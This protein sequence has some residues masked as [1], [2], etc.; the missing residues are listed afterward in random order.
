MHVSRAAYQHVQNQGGVGVGDCMGSIWVWVGDW[1]CRGT[2][3]AG[4]CRCGPALARLRGRGR[5]AAAGAAVAGLA[6]LDLLAH[7]SRGTVCPTIVRSLTEV[8]KLRLSQH[9]TVGRS[10]QREIPRFRG[11]LPSGSRKRP[12]RSL[13]Q[14]ISRI[15]CS[16]GTCLPAQFPMFSL[17][18]SQLFAGVRASPLCSNAS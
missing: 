9:K 16:W 6:A 5:Q 3:R 13:I 17:G 18:P 7:G 12:V 2:R 14:S 11:T 8:S 15:T 4:W 1:R 10:G